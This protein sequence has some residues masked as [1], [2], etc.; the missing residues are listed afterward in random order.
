MQTAEDISTRLSPVL[1][2]ALEAGRKLR[3]K[4]E[5][6]KGALRDGDE[7]SALTIAREICGLEQQDQRATNPRRRAASRLHS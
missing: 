7:T 2:V 4:L 3:F 1:D 5:A 6:M